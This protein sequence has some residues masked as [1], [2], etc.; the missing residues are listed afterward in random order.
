MQVVVGQHSDPE[1]GG[2][3][4]VQHGAYQFLILE[5]QWKRKFNKKKIFQINL[6]FLFVLPECASCIP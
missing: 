4:A 1:A 6:F 3:V 5:E 2:Q